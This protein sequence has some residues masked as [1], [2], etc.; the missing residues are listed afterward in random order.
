MFS[1]VKTQIVEMLIYLL[2]VFFRADSLS[3][4]GNSSRAVQSASLDQS[5]CQCG[6]SSW[7]GLL[8]S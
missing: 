2:A 8:F 1:L 3:T 4:L 6:G 5:L 7:P